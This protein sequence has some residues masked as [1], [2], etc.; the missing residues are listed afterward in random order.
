MKKLC[1]ALAFIA[2]TAANSAAAGGLWSV[3]Q[4][5]RAHFAH[6]SAGKVDVRRGDEYTNGDY[7]MGAVLGTIN[8]VS[9]PCIPPYYKY[10]GPTLKDPNT[11]RVTHY[12]T[13]AACERAWEHADVKDDSSQD[14]TAPY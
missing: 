8:T 11:G 9:N 14:P 13:V 2:A 4:H 5:P 10:S 6:G 12:A 7:G 3:L 1:I